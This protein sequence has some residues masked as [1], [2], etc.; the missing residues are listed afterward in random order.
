M[1]YALTFVDDEHVEIRLSATLH[2]PEGRPSL[3]EIRLLPLHH[4]VLD[5][6]EKLLSEIVSALAVH[7][8]S[9]KLPGTL[10]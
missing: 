6:M 1:D 5:Q 3:D 7:R 9:A 4:P 8:H 2:I 10:G